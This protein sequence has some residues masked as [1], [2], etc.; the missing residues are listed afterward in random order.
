MLTL[1]LLACA[2]PPNRDSDRSHAPTWHADVAP[3]VQRSCAGCHAPGELGGFSLQ[4][5]ADVALVA[6]AVREAVLQR[7]MPPWGAAEGCAEYTNSRALRED[8]V[9]TLVDWIDAGL[10]EGDP[11]S[12]P[13]EVAP[14]T[15]PSLDRVDLALTLPEP[16]TPQGQGDDYRCFL[17]EWPYEDN[18]WVTGYE[19]V[20]DNRAV[21]HHVIP[22]LIAPD[23]ADTYR[24]LDEADP[25]PGYTCYGGPGG[26]L[27]S[28]INTRWLG[29]W[30]PGGGP[31]LFPEGHGLR[32]KPGSLVAV[33]MHYNS[34]TEL[35]DPD[36]STVHLRVSTEA[37]GWADIQPWT[38]VAWVLGV[39]MEIPAQTEGVTHTFEYTAE[40]T[41]T[42][43]NVGL[44]LH[45]LGRS[46]EMRVLHADGAESCLAVVP[47]WDFNWQVRYNLAEPV[48]VGPGDTVRLS[49]TWDNPTDQTVQWGEGTG[50]EMCLGVTLLTD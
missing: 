8:E 41:F 38:D 48:A 50:E 32:V 9:Q 39:G 49:C 11:A 37:L 20:P 42:I 17:M 35:P 34:A 10:P 15:P 26:D 2:N 45:T 27:D 29:S 43:H 7:T 22:F 24:A 18:T 16:Y 23:D 13:G 21:V 40:E 1:L 44:H 12:S 33:Q 19:V 30:A 4:T 47:D 6:P 46:A 31:S 28:L 36:Q 25:G 3:I 5:A 14:A